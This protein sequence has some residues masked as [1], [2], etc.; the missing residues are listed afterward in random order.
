M[1]PPLLPPCTD[2]HTLPAANPRA[3]PVTVCLS[4][5]VEISGIVL[6]GKAMGLAG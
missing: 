1:S 3:R 2:L 5:G 4:A 6:G